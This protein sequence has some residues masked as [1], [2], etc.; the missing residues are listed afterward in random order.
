LPTPDVIGRFST[1]ASKA[2]G[3]CRLV[4]ETD[5]KGDLGDLQLRAVQQGAST[6]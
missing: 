3:Q 5:R 6:I 1:P 4:G 2:A